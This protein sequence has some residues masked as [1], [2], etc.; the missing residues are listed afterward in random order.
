[1]RFQILSLLFLFSCSFGEIMEVTGYVGKDI[2]DPQAQIIQEQYLLQYEIKNNTYRNLTFDKIVEIWSSSES[3]KS[4][5]QDVLAKTPYNLNSGE[6]QIFISN[7][8]G[9]T[10]QLLNDAK[11]T[12][13]MF[14]FIVFNKGNMIYRS[15]KIVLPS[16]SQT[17]KC[18]Q[19]LM[20][21]YDI[22][23]SDG[24]NIRELRQKMVDKLTKVKF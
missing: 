1:M 6:K 5:T 2:H 19:G 14:H 13:L 4:F 16:L 17:P 7:T 18:D 3:D 12:P 15:K 20:Y 10:L 22:E 11:G 21:S 9:Y 8:N 24:V 23:E